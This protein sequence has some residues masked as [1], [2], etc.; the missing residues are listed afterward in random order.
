[1]FH[2]SC[3][4]WVNLESSRVKRWLKTRSSNLCTSSFF[5]YLFSWHE[6][7][8]DLK[9]TWPENEQLFL[10]F[11]SIFHP[12]F[13]LLSSHVHLVTR[14]GRQS[15]LKNQLMSV[16]F[17]QI[18]KEGFLFGGITHRQGRKDIRGRSIHRVLLRMVTWI[19][20]VDPFLPWVVSPPKISG[21]VFSFF[22]STSSF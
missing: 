19:T 18:R 6:K 21:A 16:F 5:F 13:L 1:M 17:N 8:V 2:E 15:R 20:L 9:E 7:E 22:S 4:V 11:F 12:L 14:Q 3:H 10:S